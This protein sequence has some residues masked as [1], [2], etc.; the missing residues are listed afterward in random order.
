MTG[1]PAISV[2]VP[3]RNAEGTLTA[4]LRGL[5]SQDL[6]D[7]FE[8]IVVDDDSTDATAAIAERS[9]RAIL[10]QG[11]G[12]GAG[13]ARN[14][15]VRHARAGL[16]A[17]TDSD[18][19][20]EP[21]WLGSQLHALQASELVQGAV[22]PDPTAQVGPFDRTVRVTR[23]S[24]FYE[25]ANLA[26]RREL[27]DRIGG[28]QD[29]LVPADRSN[30]GGGRSSRPM[31]EDL[32]LGWMARRLRARTAFNGEAV[33]RH[34]V[35]PRSAVGFAAERRR[36]FHFPAIAKRV[37]ETRGALFFARLFLSRRSAMTDLALAAAATAGALGSPLPL[38]AC[39]P[40][41]LLL[42][43]NARRGGRRRVPLVAAV[44]LAADLIGAASLLAGSIRYRS[45]LL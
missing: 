15:G 38:L 11:S 3:A 13:A 12:D 2:I 34:A 24:G 29:W 28:F 21:S 33:V 37:P 45:V 5:E 18:C 42:T 26:V 25:T 27:F 19:V 17:F 9:P 36:L 44:D 4:T 30:R 41:V 1:N 39:A 14:L 22:V 35:F 40:Y 32:M 16:L 8:V 43:R 31:G 7:E 23:E 6:R 10:V 20:P